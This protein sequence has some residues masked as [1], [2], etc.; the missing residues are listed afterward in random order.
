MKYDQY[1]GRVEQVPTWY[2]VVINAGPE[3]PA[4]ASARIYTQSKILVEVS[5][6]SVSALTAAASVEADAS[7]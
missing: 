5:S 2:G 4:K 7:R 3:A 1:F 6:I